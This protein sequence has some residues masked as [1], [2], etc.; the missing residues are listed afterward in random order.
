MQP[1][2]H[3]G[4]YLYSVVLNVN[5]LFLVCRI[6][7]FAFSIHGIMAKKI[8]NN[9]IGELNIIISKGRMVRG[10]LFICKLRLEYLS[11]DDIE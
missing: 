7:I 4:W 2:F 6:K 5:F 3:D 11:S 1:N 8:D 9:I 10:I